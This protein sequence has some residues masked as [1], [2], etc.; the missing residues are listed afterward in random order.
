MFPLC[1][2]PPEPVISQLWTESY[3]GVKHW[4]HPHHAEDSDCYLNAPFSCHPK[5]F[6][7]WL[8]L[9]WSAKN[10]HTVASGSDSEQNGENSAINCWER[11]VNPPSWTSPDTAVSHRVSTVTAI[12]YV[13]KARSIVKGSSLGTDANTKPSCQPFLMNILKYWSSGGG[14]MQS[15]Y[16]QRSCPSMD[17][18]EVLAGASTG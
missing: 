17:E 14:I 13:C 6:P 15:P 3:G 1:H 18:M 2:F 7:L 12:L 10:F 16:R 5:Y 11:K 9:T 4:Q 8:L